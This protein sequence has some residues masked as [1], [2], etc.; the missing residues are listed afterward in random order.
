MGA[1]S[2]VPIF[3]D[4]EM[5]TVMETIIQPT[6]DGMFNDG[7]PF[8]GVLFAGLMMTKEG[9]KLIEYNVRFGDPE[10]QVLMRRLSTDLMEIFIAAEAGTLE[11]LDPVGWFDDPVV[12]VVLASKGYPGEYEKETQISGML[13][14]D[15]M[16]GVKIFHAGTGRCPNGMLIANG[17]R[18]LNVT[19]QAET[20]ELAVE[21]AYKAIDE[22]VIWPKGFC[23]RDIGH[24]ALK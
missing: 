1:F 4:K 13:D 19:A 22:A 7:H 9:P 2:P 17:G 11:D 8:V 20:L 15:D 5:Q 18:V 23:R 16:E 12:N 24:Q 21:R 14:A 6:V 3:G 10:C